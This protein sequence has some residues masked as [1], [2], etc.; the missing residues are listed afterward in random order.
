M[1]N[2]E[3]NHEVA[4]RTIISIFLTKE[5]FKTLDSE[6]PY[7]VRRQINLNDTDDEFEDHEAITSDTPTITVMKNKGYDP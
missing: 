7:S 6:S 5:M 1:D 3:G 2:Y 4:P